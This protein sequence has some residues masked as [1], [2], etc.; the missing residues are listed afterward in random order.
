MTFAE[1]FEEKKKEK[2]LDCEIRSERISFCSTDVEINS[3][4]SCIASRGWTAALVVWYA[5]YDR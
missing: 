4:T 3:Q 5:A 2:D 1:Y